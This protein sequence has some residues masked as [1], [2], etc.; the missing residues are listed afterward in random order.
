MFLEHFN[1]NLFQALNA[2]EAASDWTVKAAIFV[3]NDLFYIIVLMFLIAWF[4]GSLQVKKHI[5]KAAFF[6]LLAFIIGKIISSYFYYPRPFVMEIG[7]T[8]ID[9]APSGSFP[10]SH[11][12]F[13]S[14]IAFSFIFSKKSIGLVFLIMA[15]SVAWARIYLGVH[16]PLDMLGAFTIAFL[17][18]LLGMPLWKE[19][20]KYIINPLINLYHFIFSKLLKNGYIR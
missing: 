5:I 1:L 15:W 19:Y 16:F 11:M 10:S 6:T 3:A 2:S 18:N 9:H 17:L 8:L 20:G 4:K 13:F 7:R 14:T 12:L